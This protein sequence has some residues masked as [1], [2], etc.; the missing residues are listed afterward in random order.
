MN[1][2][3][4]SPTELLKPF[5]KT[6]LVI[7]SED[8]LINRVLPGTS[9]VMALRYKGQLNYVTDNLSIGLPISIVS[10]L[11]KSARL[12]NY[13]KDSGNILVVFK[14]VGAAAFFKEPLHD[15][16]GESVSLDNFIKQQ[17]ISAIEEQL[18]AA[19]NNAQRIAIVEGFLLSQLNTLKPD[20]LIGAAVQKI[21]SASGIIKI[22]ELANALYISN[23][24]FEKRFRK[25]IGTSPKQFSSIIRMKSVINQKQPGQNFTDLAI[26]SGYFDQPHFNKDFKLFTGQTPIDFFKAPPAW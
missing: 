7:E 15:F 24:A 20:K 18:A 9:V 23:D 5:V 19:Q 11:R 26:S 21:Q 16:F 1:V 17:K 8:E 13:S 25:V 2:N 14:E 22:R 4:Y 3:A 12:I 6:Y 10:G